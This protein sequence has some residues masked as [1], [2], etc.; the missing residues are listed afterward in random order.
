MQPSRWGDLPTELVLKICELSGTHA[1]AM[2]QKVAVSGVCRSWRQAVQTTTTKVS[3]T[4]KTLQG[5]FGALRQAKYPGMKLMHLSFCTVLSSYQESS[6]YCC[7]SSNPCCCFGLLFSP[8]KFSFWEDRIVPAASFAF[9]VETLRI[10][11]CAINPDCFFRSWLNGMPL[12]DLQLSRTNFRIPYE[13]LETF[14][15]NLPL[16]T[17]AITDDCKI[18]HDDTRSTPYVAIMRGMMDHDFHILQSLSHLTSL[19]ISA[20]WVRGYGLKYVSHLPLTNLNLRGC[21]DLRDG[22]LVYLQRMPLETVTL[23]GQIKEA[24]LRELLVRP[25]PKIFPHLRSLTLVGVAAG[26]MTR[27]SLETLRAHLPAMTIIWG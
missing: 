22:A 19:T 7:T 20:R 27:R 9:T 1:E 23:D 14:P 18:I 4:R 6:L 8:S 26:N 13:S 2:A 5:G 3:I 24:G 25:G 12:T 11:D 21:G 17:L 16:R 15:S 10:D